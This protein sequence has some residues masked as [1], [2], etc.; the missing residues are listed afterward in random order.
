MRF[1]EWYERR[2]RRTLTGVEAAEIFGITGHFAA[3]VA[4]VPR[5]GPR[6]VQG[7]P[8]LGPRGAGL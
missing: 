6:V 1:E 7:R 2:Q 3:G 4:A 5:R 8:A